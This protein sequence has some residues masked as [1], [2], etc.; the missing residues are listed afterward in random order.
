MV[1]NWF[2]KT[3]YHAN[4]TIERHKAHLVAKGFTQQVAN[5]FLGNFSPVAKL[6]TIKLLFSLAAKFC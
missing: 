4:G 5:D 1:V 6:V 3:K 2:S